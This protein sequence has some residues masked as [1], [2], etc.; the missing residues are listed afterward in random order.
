M[1]DG[2][3]PPGVTG[4]MIDHYAGE[5]NKRRCENC[6]YFDGTYCI[7]E[8]NNADEDYL[9]SE[10]DE[11]EPDDYCDDYEWNEYNDLV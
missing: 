11:R 7:R 10:R 1:F 5:D 2:A 9:I 4:A 6:L 3:Y 8:W